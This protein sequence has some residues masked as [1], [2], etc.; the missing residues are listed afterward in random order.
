MKA[1][2]VA[3]CLLLLTAA[4]CSAGDQRLRIVAAAGQTSGCAP[5]AVQITEWPAGEVHIG[6]SDRYIALVF[7][8]SGNRIAAS[9]WDQ[10][11]CGNQDDDPHTTS[12]VSIDVRTLEVTEL[13]AEADFVTDMLQWS[14]DGRYLAFIT[15]DGLVIFD[16]EARARVRALPLNGSGSWQHRGIFVAPERGDFLFVYAYQRSFFGIPRDHDKAVV[17]WTPECSAPES[18]FAE[19]VTANR[20]EVTAYYLCGNDDTPP[21]HRWKALIPLNDGMLP[22][23]EAAPGPPGWLIGND[24]I[25]QQV[26][27]AHPGALLSTGVGTDY[28]LELAFLSTTYSPSGENVRVAVRQQEAYPADAESAVVILMP[29]DELLYVPVEVD[30]GSGRG[31]EPTTPLHDVIILD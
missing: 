20:D 11:R 24:E 7:S 29:D 19:Y 2:L 23:G 30:Y 15:I 13:L 27:T 3:L 8:P 31:I 22:P 1:I 14:A 17:S 28:S 4:A 10:D 18:L 26:R 12:L 9:R 5:A 6:P 16:V 21:P 25:S